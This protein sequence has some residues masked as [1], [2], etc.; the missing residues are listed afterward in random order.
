M[1]NKQLLHY[2]NEIKFKSMDFT[3]LSGLTNLDL[4]NNPHAY[5]YEIAGHMKPLVNLSLVGLAN[6]SISSIDS[7]FFEKN[8]ELSVISLEYN[9]ISVIPFNT[10]SNLK[11]LH[12]FNLT[13]NQIS[14]LDNRTFVSLNNIGTIDFS[15]NKLT[16][17]EPNTFYNLS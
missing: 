15:L 6:L 13:Y 3:F 11:F 1:R 16:R 10:F 12:S 14:F 2:N 4:S 5:P 9:N 8:T 17:I 7:S